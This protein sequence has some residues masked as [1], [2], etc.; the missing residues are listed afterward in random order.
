MIFNHLGRISICQMYGND[1]EQYMDEI[2]NMT[3]EESFIGDN[4]SKIKSKMKGFLR[5]TDILNIGKIYLPTI[6]ELSKKMEGKL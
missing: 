6:I 1:Y 3:I 2:E 5:N 4:F